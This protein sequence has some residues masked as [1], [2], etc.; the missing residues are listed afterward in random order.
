MSELSTAYW[1]RWYVYAAVPAVFAVM[2]AT[3]GIADS[4]APGGDSIYAVVF[5]ASVAVLF[6]AMIW[7]LVGYYYDA[8]ALGETDANWHPTWWAWALAHLL[9]TPLLV[10]PLY[11]LWRTGQTGTPWANGYSIR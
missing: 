7:S 4:G 2:T 10:V 11:L 6:P 9:L 1:R 8:K 3:L 5:F